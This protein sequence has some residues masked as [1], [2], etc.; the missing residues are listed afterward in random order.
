MAR[1]IDLTAR[2]GSVVKVVT[3][4]GTISLYDQADI[5]FD[6]TTADLF[7]E[8]GLTSTSAA[9]DGRRRLMQ[10]GSGSSSGGSA[11]GGFLLHIS[12]R[13]V[14]SGLYTGV[15]TGILM[16]ALPCARN[17]RAPCVVWFQLLIDGGEHAAGSCGQLLRACWTKRFLTFRRTMLIISMYQMPHFNSAAYPIPTPHILTCTPRLVQQ[18]GRLLAS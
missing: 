8:M 1:I 15:V 16:A 2:W 11:D 9:P 7:Q 5:R 6:S 17:V 10:G 12:C 3:P 13:Y 14:V 18:R 4:L